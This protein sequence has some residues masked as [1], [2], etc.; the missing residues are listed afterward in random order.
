MC[1][2]RNNIS[3]S[4]KSNNISVS[5]KLWKLSSEG[6]LGGEIIAGRLRFSQE[7]VVIKE[8]VTFRDDMKSGSSKKHLTTRQLYWIIVNTM[9]Y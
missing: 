2:E 7:I 5:V 4:V 3:V 8:N 9:I 6:G 1:G